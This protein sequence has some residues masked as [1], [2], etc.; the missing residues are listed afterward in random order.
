MPG[1][2]DV[3]TMRR[4]HVTSAAVTKL[5]PT[6][7]SLYPVT[8]VAADTD[9]STAPPDETETSTQGVNLQVIFF[10][11]IIIACV[12]GITL[13]IFIAIYIYEGRKGSDDP[14]LLVIISVFVSCIRVIY[15]SLC[16]YRFL[17]YLLC[18]IIVY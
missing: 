11:I 8:D 14:F 3:D 18:Q 17:R 16:I 5:K 6:P 2:V 12:I 4:L 13:V 15:V 9:V 10:N 1:S 7:S